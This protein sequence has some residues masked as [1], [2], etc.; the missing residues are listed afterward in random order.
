MEW[1]SALR[2]AIG[3][4]AVGHAS[5]LAFMEKDKVAVV[6]IGAA[7]AVVAATVLLTVSGISMTEGDAFTME[8][9]GFAR[10]IQHAVASSMSWMAMAA[11]WAAALY[12]VVVCK[13]AENEANSF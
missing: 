10:N 11:G 5:V 1:T 6:A 8:P 9:G 4:V 12:S 2:F 3:I 7:S 13:A